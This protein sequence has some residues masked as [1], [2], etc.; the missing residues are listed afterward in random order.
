MSRKKDARQFKIRQLLQEEH[1]IKIADLADFFHIS[2][3]TIRK[4][5]TELEDS[6]I[7]RKEH[8]SVILLE[9][10]NEMP[11]SLRNQEYID[12]KKQIMKKACSFIKEGM[13]VYLDAGST[14]QAGI[15]FLQEIQNITIVTNSIFVAYK[16][17]RLNMHVLLIGGNISNNAYRSYGSLAS[18]TIDYIHIDVAILGSK[19]FEN[20][21]GFTSYENEYL[22]KRHVMQQ[23]EK[24]IVVADE[25]KF[26]AKS[27]YPYCKFREIDVFITNQTQEKELQVVKEIPH[28]IKVAEE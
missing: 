5:I 27:E 24:I 28:I 21:V 10:P 26:H 25:H 12:E 6:K 1:Q 14:C 18:Q 17:S 8:G 9:E 15:P 4:D 11:I 19:G 20:S 2:T 3:E 13:M 7:V 22:L 23:S 16:C